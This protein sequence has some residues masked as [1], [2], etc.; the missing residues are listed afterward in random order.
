MAWMA[1]A[2]L[3]AA[4]LF[5][6]APPAAAVGGPAATGAAMATG[7]D[8]GPIDPVT[9]PVAPG[10]ADRPASAYD[11]TNH[12]VAWDESDE[13]GGVR[14]GGTLV[15][16]DGT[17]I[18]PTGFTIS[19]G[20]GDYSPAIAFD[21][22]NY[23][24]VFYR[25]I[26]DGSYAP[27][28]YGVRVSPDGDVLGAAFPLTDRPAAQ[29]FPVVAFDGA[30]YL[31]A[32]TEFADMDGDVYAA[33]VTPAGAV[34]DPA[35]IPVAV[36]DGGQNVQGVAFGGTDFVLV[37]SDT[38]DD[39]NLLA[40]RVSPA[41]VVL[42]PAGI[43]VSSGVG[44]LA[45][46]SVAAVG[47]NVMVAWVDYGDDGASRVL[48]ARVTPTGAVPDGNGFVIDDATFRGYGP[49]I[50][51]D[52]TNALV[53]WGEGET[54]DLLG[55]RV[56]PAAVVLDP[57]AIPMA[58]G[59]ADHHGP[60]LSSDGD[61]FLLVWTDL[62]QGVTVRGVTIGGDGRPALPDGADISTAPSA[63]SSD[64]AFDGTNHLVVWSRTEQAG[65]LRRRVYAARVGPDGERLDGPG[66]VVT[67][68]AHP[69]TSDVSVSFDGTNYLVVWSDNRTNHQDIF[70]ARISPQGV[71]LDRDGIAVS[72]A[73]GE[74]SHPVVAFDGTNHLVVWEDHRAPR[75]T[76][77]W[78][79]R[80]GPDGSVQADFP[81]SRR[82][83]TQSAPAVAS[84]GADTLVVWQD[85]RLGGSDIFSTGVGTTGGAMAP[86]GRRIST[87]P[88]LQTE[89]SVGWNGGRYLVVWT[90][91]R[92]G[93]ADVYGTRVS[94]ANVV[95]DR[96]GL[97]V[98]TADDDQTGPDVVADGSRFQVAW[99]DGRSGTADVYGTRVDWTGAVLDGAGFAIASS[100]D[101]E[102]RPALTVGTGATAAVWTRARPANP[103]N[104]GILLMR[105]ISGR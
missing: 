95:Q 30:N 39:G 51:F 23:L 5:V 90:D 32:W 28:I 42:D 74:Q 22:S 33:R 71:L 99:T 105:S 41:G 72:R 61:G 24:V 92:S 21:G 86:W 77:L 38:I 53:V 25:L 3:I 2:A 79:T 102:S 66:I 57:A 87:A 68:H 1:L 45:G 81:I 13:N 31:V 59:E 91:G 46:A 67:E 88:G 43:T 96:E 4:L 69:L 78:A 101:D 34:L 82:Q 16:A 85:T 44:W 83:G 100:T 89:P 18:D 26:D 7:P 35:G 54:Y 58:A 19:G 103:T 47:P 84:D 56:T 12:L 17:V 80:V 11:G 50:G 37:W 65:G 10:L 76:N 40:A 104:E 48:G 49:E 36:L 15:A 94:A 9:D 27:D 98:S 20:P 64:V 60:A 62:R 55:A 52:G 63:A 14:I 73:F 29:Y 70:G 75:N 93:T 6:A 8:L 97:P